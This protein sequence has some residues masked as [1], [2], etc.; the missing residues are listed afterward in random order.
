MTPGSCSIEW[1]PDFF[2]LKSR[3]ADVF[4]GVSLATE[5]SQLRLC[6]AAASFNHISGTIQNLRIII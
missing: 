5:K 1:L 4:E 2:I 3:Y 6:Q